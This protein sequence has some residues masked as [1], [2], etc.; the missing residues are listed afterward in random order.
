MA[1][2]VERTWQPW[3][4]AFT[5]GIHGDR[6]HGGRVEHGAGGLD[7]LVLGVGVHVLVSMAGWRIWAFRPW[8]SPGL[9]IFVHR[10]QVS[11]LTIKELQTLETF[12]PLEMLETLEMIEILETFET[13]ADLISQVH[14]RGSSSRLIS[15]VS[16][17]RFISQVDVPGS[18]PWVLSSCSL[19]L[20]TPNDLS[21][22]D[23]LVFCP[24]HHLLGSSWSVTVKAHLGRYRN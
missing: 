16:S 6:I 7:G 19:R 11:S 4:L 15:Q 14:S 2:E 24:R 23:L 22:R 13:S 20:F 12:M 3:T 21:W 18:S 1:V 8:S 17:P 5:F 9:V 10:H